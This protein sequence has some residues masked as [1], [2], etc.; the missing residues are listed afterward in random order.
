MRESL[1]QLITTVYDIHI[2]LFH[3]YQRSS[4]GDRKATHICNKKSSFIT[5]NRL[6][7]PSNFLNRARGEMFFASPLKLFSFGQPHSLK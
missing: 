5:A 3:I 6:S 7:N 2:P 1:Q 4:H